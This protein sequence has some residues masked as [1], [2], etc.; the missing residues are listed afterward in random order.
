MKL[1]QTNIFTPLSVAKDQSL[2]LIDI[3]D[4]IWEKVIELSSHSSLTYLIVGWNTD[5]DI[6]IVT[7]WSHSSCAI[8]GLFVSDAQRPVNGSLTVSLLHSN[9]SATV[10]LISFLHDGAKATIDGCIDIA[11]HL[12]QVHSRLLE[13]NIVL[14]KNISLKTLPK[15]HVASYNVTAAHGAKI[16][17]LDQQKLFY[18]M[19]RGLTQQQSQVLLIDWYIE[20]VLGHFKDISDEE[21]NSVHTILHR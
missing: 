10:E 6:K 9:T 20:Y 3:F 16:D 13:H 21:K 5:I 12:D 7:K 11:P 8:F 2:E 19:S 4:T 14:W 18:M 17:M 1:I 15:L